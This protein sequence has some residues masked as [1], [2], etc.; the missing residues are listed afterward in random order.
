MYFDKELWRN[1]LAANFGRPY[2]ICTKTVMDTI[3]DPKIFFDEQGVSNYYYDYFR[4]GKLKLIDKAEREAE[5][6]K[7]VAKIKQDGKGRRYDCVTGLSGGVDSSYLVYLAKELGLRPLVVH[8]DNGWN[9]ETS[10]KNI[11]NIISKTGFDLYTLVVDWEEFR[12]IQLSYFKSNVIDIEAITDH[13]ISAT[14]YRLAKKEGVKYILSGNNHVT[15]GILPAYWAFNKSDS[16]NIKAI[17]KLFGTVP[18]KTFPFASLRARKWYADFYGIK[19]IELLN[20]VE[21]NKEEVKQVISDKVGWK[22]YG[23]KHYESIFTRFYQGYILPNKFGIDKRKAHLSTLV[24]SGQISRNQA[25]M[26]LEMPIY[27]DKQLAIDKEF[28]LKKLGFSENEF[29]CYIEA[30]RREHTEFD[31]EKGFFDTYK[32]LKPLKSTLRKISAKK[33]K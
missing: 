25:L 29:T 11:E 30:P 19:V 10:V 27:D 5:L 31:H 20:Y 17:H 21:Y 3:S 23:G 15:E 24:C 32:F 1:D 13:A 18:L 26:E 7:V 33:I 28:V 9:S 14:L 12:D 2:Q 6:K 16:K 4:T 8:F 22:D